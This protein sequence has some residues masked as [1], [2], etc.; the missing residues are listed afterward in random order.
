MLFAMY[1]AAI[2]TLTNEQCLQHFHDGR[3]SLLAKYRAG[4]E[5]A[6]A[7]AD[8]LNTTELGILQALAM[9]LVSRSIPYR[10]P[11]QNAIERKPSDGI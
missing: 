5:R 2:T 10:N 4:T 6:L 3:D 8:F 7:N 11:G 1:Y 9:F